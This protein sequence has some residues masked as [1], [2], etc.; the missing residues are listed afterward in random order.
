MPHT[1]FEL[2]CLHIQEKDWQDV[3]HE[4]KSDLFLA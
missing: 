1:P 3:E 2:D 4:T